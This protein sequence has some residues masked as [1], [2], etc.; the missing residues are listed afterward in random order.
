MLTEV[1]LIRVATN[2]KYISI[3]YVKFRI[4]S[5]PNLRLKWSRTTE[6]LVHIHCVL[7]AIPHPSTLLYVR[8]GS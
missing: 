6:S 2:V 7:Q 3:M 1:I 4:L 5:F 8:Q